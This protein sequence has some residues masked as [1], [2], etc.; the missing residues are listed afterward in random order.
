[1][2]AGFEPRPVRRPK[3]TRGTVT[4]LPTDVQVIGN[5]ASGLVDILLDT[6]GSEPIQT[7]RLT[8]DLVGILHGKLAK[9]LDQL[10]SIHVGQ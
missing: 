2:S 1:M 10:R 9:K 7:V 5:P 6:G 4:I 8:V 3:A